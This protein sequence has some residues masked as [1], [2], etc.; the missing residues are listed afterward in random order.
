MCRGN[1]GISVRQLIEL[2]LHLYQA[3]SQM[4]RSDRTPP[5]DTSTHSF[6]DVY[7]VP[8]FPVNHALNAT[9]CRKCMGYKKLHLPIMICSAGSEHY[10]LWESIPGWLLMLWPLMCS[11]FLLSWN[12]QWESCLQSF[13]LCWV[14][15][16]SMIRSIATFHLRTFTAI[17]SCS[18]KVLYTCFW[19]CFTSNVLLHSLFAKLNKRRTYPT[20]QISE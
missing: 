19:T 9:I 10:H 11:F 6:W 7:S 8:H 17:K 3:A 13:S 15:R 20:A 1:S 12:D 14:P 16:G 4:I 2:L 5:S 18:E